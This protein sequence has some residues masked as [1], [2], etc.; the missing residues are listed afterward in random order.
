MITTM[1]GRA[2]NLLLVP[3]A[4]VVVRLVHGDPNH[5]WED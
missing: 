1:I 5:D 2:L 4:A 3:V